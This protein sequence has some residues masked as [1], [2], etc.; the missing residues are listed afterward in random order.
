MLDHE[1]EGNTP[2]ETYSTL[3]Q[4]TLFVTSNKT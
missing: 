1:Y 3:Y 4:S 2:F